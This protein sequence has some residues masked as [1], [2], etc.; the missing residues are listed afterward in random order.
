MCVIS[1]FV[2]LRVLTFDLQWGFHWIH[3]V[4][5][6]APEHVRTSWIES[7]TSAM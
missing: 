5:G 7:I 3:W 6:R 1:I 2:D 4:E